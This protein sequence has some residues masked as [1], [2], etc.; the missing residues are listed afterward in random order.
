MKMQ[1]K[2][3]T[4]PRAGFTLLELLIVIS[5]LAIL[6][7]VIITS[8]RH[9][10]IATKRNL[11]EGNIK[12]LMSALHRYEGD[13][14]DFPPSLGDPLKGAGSLYECLMTEKK[15][16]PYIKAGDIKSVDT[17]NGDT[18]FADGWGRPIY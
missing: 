15:G 6:A 8:I 13:F 11:T 2:R 4:S 3:H 7:T 1:L 18:A 14:D 5:I 10:Q 12:L 16:G 17:G 9:A